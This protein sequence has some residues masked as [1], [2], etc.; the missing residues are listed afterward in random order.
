[1]EEDR[2]PP[3][4]ISENGPDHFLSRLGEQFHET[5]TS[6]MAEFQ[7]NT[8]QKVRNDMSMARLL[9]AASARQS[10]ITFQSF[11]INGTW[12]VRRHSPAPN[13]SN[14]CACSVAFKCPDPM[15]TGGRFLCKYGNNCA[16]GTTV[17]TAPGLVTSC[18]NFETLLDSDLRCFFDQ[19]CF[20]TLLSMF[21][22]DMPDRLPLPS[23]TRT[24]TAMNSSV[25][26]RFLPNDTMG[27]LFNELMIEEWQLRSSFEGYYQSC[28]PAT[29]KY[30]VS[31][32]ADPFYVASLIVSIFGGL[33]VTFRL[34]VPVAARLV[35]WI[36]I[37]WRNRHTNDD[38]PRLGMLADRSQLFL[39]PSLPSGLWR[40]MGVT[41]TNLKNL[42]V[43]ANSFRKES[44]TSTVPNA[45]QVAIRSTRLYV[46]LLIIGMVV[47]ALVN[48]LSE[49]T[50]SRTVLKP[51]LDT[52]ERL[53]TMYPKTLSCPCQTFSVS[54]GSFISMA[55]T[56]HQVSLI[57]LLPIKPSDCVGLFE[58]IRQ[59]NVGHTA[60]WFWRFGKRLFT[61][62]QASAEQAAADSRMAL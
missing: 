38:G 6:L 1:M 42:L 41:L 59:K 60:V 46:V 22:V 44:L 7:S 61:A 55:V 15:W 39:E 56:Y 2:L 32:R 51:S 25:P 20:S 34:L 40:R 54:Y 23:A 53:H 30:S 50:V 16:R 18:T 27:T 4:P 48:G 5:A 14:E 62:G 58:R 21:N 12:A 29:C 33:I 9:M 31:Q 47:L 17:W 24:L 35:Y 45:E 57:A 28:A 49:T 3:P 26:S 36:A 43:K 37:Y 19:T 8:K 10:G 13:S 11:E 52:F